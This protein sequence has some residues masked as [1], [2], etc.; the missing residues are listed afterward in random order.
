VRKARGRQH[1]II[2]GQM[3]IRH[4][5][6]NS[7]P[8]SRLRIASFT[9]IKWASHKAHLLS[10]FVRNAQRTQKISFFIRENRLNSFRRPKPVSVVLQISTDPSLTFRLTLGHVILTETKDLDNL[11]EAI[12]TLFNGFSLVGLTVTYVSDHRVSKNSRVGQPVAPTERP[13]ILNRRSWRHANVIQA[14]VRKSFYQ[15]CTRAI[16]GGVFQRALPCVTYSVAMGSYPS[17]DDSDA[18]VIRAN[19]SVRSLPPTTCGV[20]TLRDSSKLA[21]GDTA[22]RSP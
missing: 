17:N 4:T 13:R 10:R 16:G 15:Y 21:M 20:P 9:T 14:G 8:E 3:W 11:I 7:V 12:A 19:P 22:I 18:S 5:T 2:D 1:A 6:E